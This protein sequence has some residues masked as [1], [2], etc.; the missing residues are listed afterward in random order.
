ML[1]G[2]LDKLWILI[3]KEHFLIWNPIYLNK[4]THFFIQETSIVKFIGLPHDLKCTN[5]S[6]KQSTFPL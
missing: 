3:L 6:V 2:S 4:N 5:L 1:G